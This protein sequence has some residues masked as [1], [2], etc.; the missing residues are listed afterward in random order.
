MPDS[1]P[2]H[3]P[4]A[5]AVALSYSRDDE[6]DAPR[7]VATGRGVAAEHIL[8]R[9]HEHGVPVERD[10]DLANCLVQ[11]PVGT[12]IPPAAWEATARILAFLWR[13]N[14]EAVD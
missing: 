2:R 5:S 13:K 8:D 6:H 7:V 12:E 11:L 14:A 1:S 3:Q 10:P 9:A 4:T